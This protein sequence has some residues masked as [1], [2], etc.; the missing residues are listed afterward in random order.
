MT[1]VIGY[2]TGAHILR[3]QVVLRPMLG[4]VLP[5]GMVA[6][7]IPLENIKSDLSVFEPGMM[8]DIIV[9]MLFVPVDDMF[10]TP[11]VSESTV[12]PKRIMQR[13]VDSVEILTIVERDGFMMMVVSPDEADLVIWIVEAG[14][15]LLLAQVNG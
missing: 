2:F 6:V 8:V 1:E 12:E 15:P 3:E 11:D 4:Q 9:G 14:L 10:Q 13:V 5:P 7:S